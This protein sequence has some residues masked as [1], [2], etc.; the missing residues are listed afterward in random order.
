MA[1]LGHLPSHLFLSALFLSA[2]S[3]PS[4]EYGERERTVAGEAAGDVANV[5]GLR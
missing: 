1:S 4:L 3:S 2:L 5:L